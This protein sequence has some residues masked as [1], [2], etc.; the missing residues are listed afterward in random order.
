MMGEDVNALVAHDQVLLGV[1]VEP[2]RVEGRSSPLLIQPTTSFNSP[3]PSCWLGALRPELQKVALVKDAEPDH[4]AEHQAHERERRPLELR[5]Q[6]DSVE[7]QRA[8][9]HAGEP[10]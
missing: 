5:E 8:Q 7:V 9:R 10:T 3:E 4:L 1:P 2:R 6:M